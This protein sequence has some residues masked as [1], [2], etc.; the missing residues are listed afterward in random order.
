MGSLLICFCS[1]FSGMLCVLGIVLVVNFVG[2]WMLISVVLVVI[3]LLSLCYCSE[4]VVLVWVFF[5]MELR[6]F[7]VFLVELNCGV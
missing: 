6:M 3:V 1:L 7:M 4:G 2:E 5:V